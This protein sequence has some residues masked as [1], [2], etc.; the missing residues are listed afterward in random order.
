MKLIIPVLMSVVLFFQSCIISGGITGNGNIQSKEI[1]ITDYT[2][3]DLSGSPKLTYEQKPGE[4]P[5]LRIE[6]DENLLSY[7][8]AEVDNGT[9][10]METT[11]NCNFTE[12]RI[13][14]NSTSL[15]GIALSGSGKVVL[16]GNIRT[17]T[18]ELKLSGSGNI[19]VADLTCT[20]LDAA[21]SGSGT[22]NLGGQTD[23]VELALSGSGQMKADDLS[24]KTA[25]SKVSGSGKM[26][27]NAS[28]TL[29]A[30]V[31]GSGRINYKGN[32]LHLNKTV[33]GSGKI[34][35]E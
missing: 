35:S 8:E 1:D 7:I 20:S 19:Q 24:T 31:S 26:S 34:K 15:Q 23:R 22:I 21:L 6:T 13:Y 17:E 16:D 27:V 2:S 30:I 9:L 28:D 18:L 14:T 12:Y 25:I 10:R 33:S 3:I 29:D 11:E 32:P 5:Y 4:K